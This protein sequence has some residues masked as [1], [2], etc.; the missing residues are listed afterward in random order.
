[1]VRGEPREA[2]PVEHPEGVVMRPG[3]DAVAVE[4]FLMEVEL[5]VEEGGHPEVVVARPEVT[6]A[7]EGGEEELHLINF[8]PVSTFSV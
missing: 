7:E 1:M 4:G 3:V 8:S 5:L 6:A 2:G